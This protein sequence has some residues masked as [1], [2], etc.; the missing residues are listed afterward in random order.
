MSRL[1]SNALKS[2]RKSE[3]I[4]STDSSRQD[5]AFVPWK[6]ST[7]TEFN[8]KLDNDVSCKACTLK[9][10]TRP[11]EAGVGNHV[12]LYFEWFGKQ[13]LYEAGCDVVS[14][15]PWWTAGPLDKSEWTVDEIHKREMTPKKVNR[16]ALNLDRSGRCYDVVENN[17]YWWVLDFSEALG[18]EIDLSVW[19]A[20]SFAPGVPAIVEFLSNS[21]EQ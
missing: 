10:V 15:V 5:K 3:H 12:A 16:T 19:A 20:L 4:R 7:P 21:A 9:V 14:L 2:S 11:L 1:N 17:C 18:I 6:K 8:W 13:A